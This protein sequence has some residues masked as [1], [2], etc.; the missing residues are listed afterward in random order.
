[1]RKRFDDTVLNAEQVAE[2]A[3][4]VS[5]RLDGIVP[6]IGVIAGSGLSFGNIEVSAR[7][8]YAEVPYLPEPGVA[9]H[10][11]EFVLA[12][13]GGKQALIA[14]GRLHRYEG[15]SWDIITLPIRIFAALGCKH[16]ILTA[17]VGATNKSIAPGDIAVIE[18]HINLM[19]GN[20]LAGFADPG[21]GD[22]FVDL[23]NVYDK[24]LINLALEK[25]SELNLNCHIGVY[26]AVLGPNYETPAEVAMIARLGGDV[27]GMS[28]IPET[29][30]AAQCGLPVLGIC[31]IGNRAG[32][33][34]QHEGVVETVKS[35]EDGITR[36]ISAVIKD[37]GK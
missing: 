25:A 13:L 15:H 33:P 20:P 7:I 29:I 21:L 14:R 1:M 2:S 27:V 17:A 36:L 24:A 32:E 8:P 6:E 4:A 26:A 35:A 12:E 3:N 9:G 31:V 23:Y 5:E 18:D 11:G 28:V 30:V 19:G 10:S 37:M 34:A 16:L 22:R